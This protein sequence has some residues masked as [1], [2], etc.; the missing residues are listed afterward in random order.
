[1]CRWV[2]YG[3]LRVPDSS[4]FQ[5]R[6]PLAFQVVPALILVIGMVFVPE[7]PRFLVEKGRHA[8]AIRVL[9]RLHYDGTNDEWI[10]A[11]FN[12]I[13]QAIGSGSSVAPGWASMFTVP[14]WRTRMLYVPDPLLLGLSLTAVDMVWLFRCLPR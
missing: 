14:K 7:S 13:C 5:W 1:M 12:E 2:G 8:E 9:R 4:Q 6:F 10:E 11:E 3:F